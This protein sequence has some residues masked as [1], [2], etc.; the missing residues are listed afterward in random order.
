MQKMS[1]RKQRI[2]KRLEALGMVFDGQKVNGVYRV[3][4]VTCKTLDEVEAYITGLEK[5]NAQQSVAPED[6][7]VEIVKSAEN[8]QDW[9]VAL[10]H[11]KVG[12]ERTI[13]A[14][15]DETIYT[16]RRENDG[17]LTALVLEPNTREIK[18]LTYFFDM[19]ELCNKIQE[20]WGDI[21]RLHPRDFQKEI[22]KRSVHSVEML[23]MLR[24]NPEGNLARR[25]VYGSPMRP[26]SSVW[27]RIPGAAI[28]IPC[29]R[30]KTGFHT[31]I[32]VLAR[33]DKEIIEKY[34]L[35]FVSHGGVNV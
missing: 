21:N 26:M 28:Y 16:T 24:D 18:E 2:T 11:Q 8:W 34:D 35:V 29:N 12:K 20:E 4:M 25:F 1:I 23:E 30:Q 13:R 17:T 32:A 7:V 15:S 5:A 27:A 33:L 9:R 22:D 19:T 31:Y 6:D 14:M 10:K 3:G